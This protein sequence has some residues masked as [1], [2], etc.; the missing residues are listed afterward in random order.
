MRTRHALAATVV[1]SAVAALALTGC[2]TASQDAGSTPGASGGSTA[3]A[4]DLDAIQKDDAVAAL[5]PAA[6]AEDG[7][8]SIGSNLEY[9]PVEFVDADG[10][11]P[12]GLDIDIATALAKTMGLELEVNNAGFDSIIPAIGSKYEAG[13]SAFSVTPER[14]K[15]VNMVGYFTAGSQFAVAKGNP[16]DVSPD[17]LCGVT[18]GVQTGTIQQDELAAA[19]KECTDG[20]K[21][22]VDVLPY[23]SQSDVTTNLAGGK[24]QAMYADSPI[25]AYAVEQ[26]GGSVEALGEITD[27]APYGAVV[28]KDDTELAKAV[29]A[30]LQKLMDD[31]VLAQVADAW[32]SGAAV[33]DTA[34]LNPA[35]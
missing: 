19:S 12:V 17:D 26:T 31:G 11:T 9:A 34:E 32:G 28:A 25:I 21:D 6:V 22:A 16:E 33:L 30:G 14:L 2:T 24:L 7:K 1:T 20:G 23:D 8:L 13:F 10:T 5:V 29:Q 18:V 4:V 15:E 3:A 35:G 27:A